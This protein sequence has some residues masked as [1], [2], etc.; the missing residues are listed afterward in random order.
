MFV[1]IQPNLYFYHEAMAVPDSRNRSGA[2]QSGRCMTRQI[3]FRCPLDTGIGM[4]QKQDSGHDAHDYGAIR[5][6]LRSIGLPN[7]SGST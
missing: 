6:I 2:R 7:C 4:H 1:L 3:A 5:K